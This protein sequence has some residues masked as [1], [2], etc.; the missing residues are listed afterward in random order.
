MTTGQ[1]HQDLGGLDKRQFLFVILSGCWG[2]VELRRA[3]LVGCLLSDVFRYQSGGRGLRSLR[4]RDFHLEVLAG[5]VLASVSLP[6]GSGSG[7]SDPDRVA[8]RL[9]GGQKADRGSWRG[10]GTRGMGKR[11]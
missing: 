8:P 6:K 4:F 3:N 10:P 5:S 11:G 2:A 7:C 9:R 1:C